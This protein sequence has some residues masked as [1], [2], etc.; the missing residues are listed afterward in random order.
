LLDSIYKK[1]RV[2]VLSLWQPGYLQETRGFPSLPCGRFGLSHFLKNLAA[3]ERFVKP[4]YK[5]FVV[6]FNKNP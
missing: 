3:S 4:F 2:A 6:N 5:V 1:K